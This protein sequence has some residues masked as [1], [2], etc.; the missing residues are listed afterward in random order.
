VE[1][2][3]L[4]S[5]WE[6]FGAHNPSISTIR[7]RLPTVTLLA[8][9][10]ARMGRQINSST[11]KCHATILTK[12]TSLSTVL[13]PDSS[14]CSHVL[15]LYL[16]HLWLCTSGTAVGWDWIVADLYS[17]LYSWWSFCSRDCL[18]NYFQC[19]NCPLPVSASSTIPFKWCFCLV[20]CFFLCRVLLGLV[21]IPGSWWPHLCNPDPICVVLCVCAARLNS[22]LSG[23]TLNHIHLSGHSTKFIEKITVRFFSSKKK[24]LY[25]LFFLTRERCCTT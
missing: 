19:W 17:D 7:H 12:S 23:F 10:P 21:L 16:T 4:T 24:K 14:F 25:F 3:C 13:Y 11:C 5:N 6:I 15:N 18:L 22:Y 8:N 20:A 1:I 9:G 2:W